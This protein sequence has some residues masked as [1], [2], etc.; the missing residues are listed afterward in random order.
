[1]LTGLVA[2]CLGIAGGM[3]L[4]PLFISLDVHPQVVSH[5]LH[6]AYSFAVQTLRPLPAPR[7]L[8]R[9]KFPELALIPEQRESMA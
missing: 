9:G 7:A 5:G 8:T 1:M 4:G 6:Q 2:G 3:I